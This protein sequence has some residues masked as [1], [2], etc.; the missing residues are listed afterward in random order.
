MM[1]MTRRAILFVGL[2]A[3]VAAFAADVERHRQ[4]LTDGIYDPALPNA[5][6]YRI[7]REGIESDD[8]ETAYLTVAALTLVAMVERVA[9]HG[10]DDWYL[11]ESGKGR[12]P[13]RDYSKVPGLKE[14]LIR[15]WREHH[16]EN[17][18]DADFD[19]SDRAEGHD[20]SIDWTQVSRSSAWRA[21]LG[22]LCRFYP[23]DPEVHDLLWE[24]FDHDL[25]PKETLRSMML[26]WLNE[27]GFAT[28]KADTYRMALLESDGN[29][30]DFHV[31][32]AVK[33]LALAR[34]PEALPL[35]IEA[36]R[37]NLG[38]MPE[39]AA[40]IGAYPNSQ[41]MPYVE[42]LQNLVGGEDATWREHASES[43]IKIMGRLE[44]LWTVDEPQ[45]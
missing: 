10:I 22:V 34:R 29:S 4:F 33:G 26:T 40:A 18:Y 32:N 28:R 25:T 3:S 1:R 36:W 41:L 9:E 15:Y 31:R 13:R 27:G 14:F 35:L 8:S 12:M 17:D 30:Q 11:A 23:G 42:E 38:H 37:N 44:Y 16:E 19:N 43:T 2:V 39:I 5:E 21:T 45:Q 24:V 6:A 7:V 20:G